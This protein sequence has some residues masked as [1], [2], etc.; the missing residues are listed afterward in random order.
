MFSK[1]TKRSKISTV[2]NYEDWLKRYKKALRSADYNKID[3]LVEIAVYFGYDIPGKERNYIIR[4]FV[5]KHEKHQE[6]MRLR[7]GEM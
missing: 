5:K 2:K 7:G 1:K 4:A 6:M 3:Q